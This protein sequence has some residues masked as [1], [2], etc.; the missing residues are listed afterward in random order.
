MRIEVLVGS[1]EP[2]IF[3]LKS[4]RVSLGSSETCDIVINSSGV[5]RKHLVIFSESDKFF[6]SDQG[7]TNGT[8]V[9]EERLVPGRRVEFTS[10]FPL[11]LGDNVLVSLLSDDEL[12]DLSDSLKEK[13]SP[14]IVLPKNEF[15]Q[16]ST[17]VISLKDLKK[18]KTEKLITTRDKKRASSKQRTQP[19]KKKNIQAVPVFAALIVAS[20]LYYTMFLKEEVVVDQVHE[21]GKIVKVEPMPSVKKNNLIPKEDLVPREL[22][23]VLIGDIKCTSDLEIYMCDLLRLKN[24]EGVVQQGLS[25]NVL[26]DISPYKNEALIYLAKNKENMT[27]DEEII[28]KVATLVYFL[29]HSPEVDIE[30]LK[31]AKLFFHFF[32][33][34][35]EG[36]ALKVVVAIY[37]EELNHLIKDKSSNLLMTFREEPESKLE[38]TKDYFRFY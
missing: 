33:K 20:A 26:I 1:D 37:P 3:P 35:E 32:E 22:F 8:F 25:L 28:N 4:S 9:N 23:S 10:F 16:D 27:S 18:A 5:S 38:F 14:K 34:L 12:Q 19:K 13:S 36:N 17:R 11:R 29:K 21:V 24:P 15:S 6:V 31:Y 7:S 30:K 2:L